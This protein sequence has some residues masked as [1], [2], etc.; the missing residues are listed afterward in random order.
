M[1]V[2]DVLGAKHVSD[3]ANDI[4][5]KMTSVMQLFWICICFILVF[6]ILCS[7]FYWKRLGKVLIVDVIDPHCERFGMLMW[8]AIKGKSQ[9]YKLRAKG[10]KNPLGIVIGLNKKKLFVCIREDKDGHIVIFGGT[11]SGK[12]SQILIPT[13]RVFRGRAFVID[14]SGDISKKTK[15]YRSKALTFAPLSEKSI[16]YD[17]YYPLRRINVKSMTPHVEDEINNFFVKLCYTL[18]PDEINLGDTERYYREGGRSMLTAALVYYFRNGWDFIPSCREF[19]KQ[20]AL[21]LLEK[22]N[23]MDCEFIKIMT[24]Q[25]IGENEKNISGCKSSANK[26]IQVFAT[27]N[28][29]T[30]TMRR[31]RPDEKFVIY[32]GVIERYDIYVRIPEE[33]LA[34]N[35]P[36]L[37][38]IT[39]QM[40]SYMEQRKITKES[41]VVLLC[42]D[43]FG[44]LKKI[45]KIDDTLKT[46]RKRK[47]RCVLMTQS[48]ADFE[49]NYGVKEAQA[50]LDNL[51]YKICLESNHP[52][53]QEYFSKLVG[54]DYEEKATKSHSA[55]SENF[56]QVNNKDYI[57]EP[58]KLQYIKESNKLLYIS[59]QGYEVLDKYIYWQDKKRYPEDYAAWKA[60]EKAA[61]A[62]H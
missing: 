2:T 22:I 5:Q 48:V 11:G 54:K 13:L 43:E 42:I 36:V 21:D 32:P 58:T 25:F 57:V 60:T 61:R 16:P 52:E 44:R 4:N 40:L 59:P 12:T 38:L 51:S 7:I 35:A 26:F 6:F 53:T 39:T 56:G 41:P 31:K 33:N 46:I 34:E 23:Y 15:K 17:V 62:R 14:I 47:G 55:T 24:S 8:N 29:F 37:A 9:K 50:M 19:A 10:Y 3:V 45:N 28:T 18:I 30:K 20:S 1:K 49:I 27:Q